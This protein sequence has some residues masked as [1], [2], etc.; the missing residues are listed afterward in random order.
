MLI[1][2]L[3]KTLW[4]KQ[5]FINIM[6]QKYNLY[7]SFPK[8]LHYILA[9]IFFDLIVAV[10]CNSTIL[11]KI[12]AQFL[13]L[14]G[15]PCFSIIKFIH[16]LASICLS[17]SVSNPL[18]TKSIHPYYQIFY[19]S[20]RKPCTILGLFLSYLFHESSVILSNKSFSPLSDFCSLCVSHVSSIMY[21]VVLAVYTSYFSYQIMQK[22]T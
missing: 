18:C 8:F 16:C 19:N 9:Y 13:F 11:F 6:V 20:L 17:N 7:A 5:R 12:L 1:N 4:I 2:I 22:V 14:N 3:K 10:F 21:C 15:S